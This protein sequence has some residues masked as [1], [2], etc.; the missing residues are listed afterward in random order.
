MGSSPR[1]P[2]TL[3]G[4]ATFG[5]WIAIAS[6]S[7]TPTR[8]PTTTSSRRLTRRPAV[9]RSM[10]PSGR[11][12]TRAPSSA[13]ALAAA[14]IG[15]PKRG[16]RRPSSSTYRRTIISARTS[17]RVRSRTRTP[18]GSMWA[19]RS[20]TSSGRSG[21]AP[22]LV[23][24]GDVLF[25]GGTQDRQFR[26]FNA[27]TGDQLWSFPLPSGAIGVPTSFEVD[28]QQYIAVTTGWDLDARGVQNGLDAIK[29]TTTV[30]PQSG[31]VLVFKLQ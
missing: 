22:V 4:T 27:R 17:Q 16:A 7:C 19:T 24:A 6:S 28:G 13:R 29:K 9:R 5:S 3:A 31:T 26:A 8:S 11:G 1:R 14:K 23:T 12:R 15:R 25:A 2:H 21:L 18:R 30:V 20:T 10:S